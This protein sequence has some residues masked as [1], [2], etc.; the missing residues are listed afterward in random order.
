MKVI[1]PS[2]P[3]GT[4]LAHAS[5]VAVKGL[6]VADGY[7]PLDVNAHYGAGNPTVTTKIE[8]ADLHRQFFKLYV[9]G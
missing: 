5:W 9:K 8:L 7:S 6:L 4:P 3:E 2:K 1:K